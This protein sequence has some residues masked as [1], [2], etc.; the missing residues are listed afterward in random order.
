MAVFTRNARERKNVGLLYCG[1]IYGMYDVCGVY[2]IY[3][4]CNIVETL[5]ATSL[6]HHAPTVPP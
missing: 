2:D 5:H 3:G 6:P 1:G 4:V